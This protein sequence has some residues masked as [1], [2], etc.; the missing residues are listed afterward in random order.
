MIKALASMGGDE[1]LMYYHLASK[2]DYFEMS[3]SIHNVSEMKLIFQD[4]DTNA[5]K[6]LVDFARQLIGM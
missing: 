3:N 5:L 6:Q 2:I 1:Y 4:K